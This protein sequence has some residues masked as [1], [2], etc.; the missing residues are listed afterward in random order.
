MK[1]IHDSLQRVFERH[2]IVFWYD[3]EKEWTEDFENF[4]NPA[5][6]KLRV[7]GDEFSAKVRVVREPDREKQ[8]LLYLPSER[9]ADADNWLLDLLLQ[10]YQYKADR[11]SLA[12]LDAG[13]P[14]EFRH[15][16][17]DHGSYFL[18]AKRIQ[19]LRERVGKNDQSRDLRL[20]MMAVLAGTSVEIDPLLL[21]FLGKAVDGDLIDPVVDCLGSAALVQP[22]WREVEQRFGYTADA[23]SLQDFAVNLFRGSNPLDT[24]VLLHAHARVF[25][26]RWKDSQSGAASFRY[27]S[28]GLE[29][30]LHIV[31]TLDALGERE[32]LGEADAFEAFEKFTL[33]RLCSAFANNSAAI[34]L[35]SAMQQR[36]ASFWRTDHQHGYA[37]IEHAV[38]LRELLAG[39]ELNVESVEAGFA[40]YIGSWWRID[41]A[42]RR[43]TFHL[44]RY[45]QVQLMEQ[46]SRWVEGAYV[47]NF[48]LPLTDR[49]GDQVSRLDTWA[50]PGVNSQRRFFD[51][52]VNPFLSRDQ[53]VFVIVSDALRY[54]A[55][56]E[57]A[58]RL[59]LANR[60]TAEVET[61]LGSLPSYTQ[62]GMA[63][64]LPARNGRWTRVVRR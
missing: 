60:F 36:R 38:E 39:V 42:Y 7:D 40:R 9:P 1:R 16:A 4:E 33:H 43:C 59:R 27:W 3:G 54:E 55:A 20:K 8:F 26:Q 2:R 37:A 50:C 48:L 28:H 19:A 35:R 32:S 62:L 51:L 23:P 53:K 13:L 17:E 25:L 10:G 18:S 63:A 11:A 47:N 5:V 49:W 45:G 31:A 29:G 34:D 30:D 61:L 14:E 64:L 12:L 44:R 52:Y 6:T 46:I 57:F 41:L 22:F 58:G 15:L 56:A 21:H 24:Q